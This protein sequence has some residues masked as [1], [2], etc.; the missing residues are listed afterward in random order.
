MLF[1]DE[2]TLILSVEETDTDAGVLMKLKGEL[3]RDVAR[4]IQDELDAFITV[5]CN[6]VM[7]LKEVGYMAS[8]F[9]Y[10][11]L[12]SQQLIDHFRKGELVLKN[13]PT[14]IYEQMDKT[15]IVE[16]LMIED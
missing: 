8:S 6:V 16:L 2:G 15:G 10:A 5:G 13:I 11:L 7:D 3:T 14:P 4:H 1:Y 12:D 9:L